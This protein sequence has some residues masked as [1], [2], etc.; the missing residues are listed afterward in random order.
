LF[1][2]T[3]VRG[4]VMSTNGSENS[5][6]APVEIDMRDLLRAKKLRSLTENKGAGNDFSGLISQIS[7]PSVR[8]V[9]QLVEGL[10][11]MREK[12]DND[13]DRLHREIARY[14]EFSETVTQLTKIVSD[15]MAHV[16]R[17]SAEGEA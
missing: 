13:G 17:A 11:Q 12:L 7:A 14:A 4:G 1:G 5:L 6:I 8:E 16:K 15:G 3:K 9:D 2:V 10:R